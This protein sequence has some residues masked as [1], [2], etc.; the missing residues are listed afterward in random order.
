[1]GH[2]W[3]WHY[4]SYPDL[5]TIYGPAAEGSDWHA[6][7]LPPPSLPSLFSS[8]QRSPPTCSLDSRKRTQ[9]AAGRHL[10]QQ[11]QERQ[12][13]CTPADNPAALRPMA[14]AWS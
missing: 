5:H 6:L 11:R 1:M 9:Q 10:Q 14:P 2:V 7:P 3:V 12:Q 13:L 8:L 4:V